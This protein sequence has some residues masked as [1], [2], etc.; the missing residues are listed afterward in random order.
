MGHLS[1]ML[2]GLSYDES[3]ETRLE[4]TIHPR[5]KVFPPV[6]HGDRE[7]ER[8]VFYLNALY[9]ASLY[10]EYRNDKDFRK[11]MNRFMEGESSCEL[12]QQYFRDINQM[13]EN[14]IF[15]GYGPKRSGKSTQMRGIFRGYAEEMRCNLRYHCNNSNYDEFIT[16]DVN[17]NYNFKMQALKA[18]DPVAFEAT[19]PGFEACEWDNEPI[20]VY[21][22]FDIAQTLDDV[23]PRMKAR[24]IFYQDE[25]PDVSGQQSNSVLADINTLIDASSGQL[26]INGT[27]ISPHLRDRGTLKSVQAFFLCLGYIPEVNLS[28]AMVAVPQ[29]WEGVIDIDTWEPPEVTARYKQGAFE[30]KKRILDARGSTHVV[31]SQAKRAPMVE[32]LVALFDDGDHDRVKRATIERLA[33]DD[34]VITTLRE[35]EIQRV[36]DEAWDALRKRG[37]KAPAP[38]GNSTP[39]AP[40]KKGFVL[41]LDQPNTFTVDDDVLL[42]DYPDQVKAGIY[43][44]YKNVTGAI[45]Q[46][47]VA[48]VFNKTQSTISRIVSPKNEGIS[49]VPGW[50]GRKRGDLY[51]DHEDGFVK[52]LKERY[53]RFIKNIEHDTDPNTRNG[54]ADYI[55]WF[56]SND[57]LVA[58]A[59]TMM[60]GKAHGEVAEIMARKAADI[61]KRTFG[62]VHVY[63]VKCY[64]SARE[65]HKVYTIPLAGK[66]N[67]IKAEERALKKILEQQPGTDARLVFHF[68]NMYYKH[69]GEI[70]IPATHEP[71]LTVK[72]QGDVTGDTNQCSTGEEP[73]GEGQEGQEKRMIEVLIKSTGWNGFIPLPDD[74]IIEHP[75]TLEQY[76]LK[77]RAPDILKHHDLTGIIFR[78]DGEIDVLF[79]KKEDGEN[80]KNE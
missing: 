63:S 80:G 50:L 22:S 27:I 76:D 36:I 20:D 62:D 18:M 9:R 25:D 3:E 34:A 70:D 32:R 13:H 72:I 17:K 4:R 67:E 56:K 31:G 33:Y 30:S 61:A 42:N 39:Q 28:R 7:S 43:K 23:I 55:V 5:E 19:H 38:A 71:S 58:E 60:V 74:L 45:S 53:G 73:G 49:T 24:D 29:G 69:W 41:E 57:E 65:G 8:S 26:E 15:G 64:G 52:T 44:Y 37:P 2:K 78:E 6:K 14:F 51:E 68:Y 12:L 75:I 35:K 21:L 16:F 46:T 40:G 47:E 1:F 77:A 59:K 10:H 66:K 48:K 11:S 79:N 54:K